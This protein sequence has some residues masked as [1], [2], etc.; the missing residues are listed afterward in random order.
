M[1][2][3]L[4]LALHLGFG[5]A[6]KA[7]IAEANMLAEKY[8]VE[9]VSVY[10]LYD[11][12]AFWV[13]ERVIIRYL[14]EDLK[15]NK[16]ELEQA[17]REKNLLLIAK[18]AWKSFKV[19]YYRK[20][21]IIQEIK[22]TDADIIISTRFLYNAILGK[23]KKQNV[24]TIAQEH[25]H[26][27]NNDDYIEKIVN[28]IKNIDFF[29]PVSQE[30]TDFYATKVSNSKCVYIPHSLEYIPER[31][32][33]LKEKNI[34]SVGRLSKEKGFQ[35]LIKVFAIFSKG[36]EDW[37][38]NI[39]GDGEER[40]TI[41]ELIAEYGLEEKVILHGYQRKEYINSLLEKSSI[42]TMTSLEE[43]FGIVLIEA[44]SFGIPCIA[45]D[46]ARGALEIIKDKENGFLIPN[47]DLKMMAEKIDVLAQDYE[48]RRRLG[49]KARANSLQYSVEEIKNKWFEFIDSI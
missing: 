30:L 8:N 15:P 28:S 9:I 20:A 32:S 7:I 36:H 31:C 34:I 4:F 39:V 49:E 6:E 19:L 46:S 11:N 18:E 41:E 27:K 12:P 43:A 10:R 13:D 35:D 25:N 42:Y 5:G 40:R 1:K 3:I 16:E 26:H 45:F 48:L 17:I 14:L 23:Y 2:K 33:E 24:V 47:R 44:Q 38:L 29:M 37:K 21:K 22:E